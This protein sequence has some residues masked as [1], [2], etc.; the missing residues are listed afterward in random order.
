M[1]TKEQIKEELKEQYGGKTIEDLSDKDLT[2]IYK[3]INGYGDKNPVLKSKDI[4]RAMRF[5]AELWDNN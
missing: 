1:T 4:F 2:E 3:K 5:M